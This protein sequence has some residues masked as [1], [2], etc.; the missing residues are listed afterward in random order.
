MQHVTQQRWDYRWQ[1]V[2]KKSQQ[3]SMKKLPGDT[4]VMTYGGHLV[5]QTL[6]RCRFSPMFTTG[7]VSSSHFMSLDCQ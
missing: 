6:L 3:N 4:S 2:P 1:N 7:Q 5:K